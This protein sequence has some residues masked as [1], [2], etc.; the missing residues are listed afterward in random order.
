MALDSLKQQD[1]GL[2]DFL[3]HESEMLDKT[4]LISAHPDDEVLWFSSVADKVDKLV[5]CFLGCRSK[6]HWRAG[7]EK[8][9]REHPV[10][11]ISCLGLDE[12]ETFSAANWQNP[13]VTPFGIEIADK[14][15]S[16][17]QYRENYYLLE[18]QLEDILTDFSN[19]ITHNP[20]GEYGNEEHIQVY[21]AVKAL[22]PRMGFNLWFS[23]YC[24]NSSFKLM[25]EYIS[26]FD[27]GYVTLKTNKTLGTAAMNL[28][29]K[30][31]CW[32]WYDDWEWFGQESF[33]KDRDHEGS[34]KQ[35]GHI[36][37]TNTIKFNYPHR[38]PAKSGLLTGPMHFLLAKAGESKG[39]IW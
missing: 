18:K 14:K 9:L 3:P 7:R 19:V 26:G 33:M 31:H 37:P 27:S 28:Y 4:V 32:T 36:F 22:Q 34:A 29:K 12:S 20:W 15:I 13:V 1:K 10:G 30:Y 21:R 38:R 39:W 11:K 25:F 24:S 5:I 6:P 23:N 17:T 8:S 2:T 16:D 35:Y